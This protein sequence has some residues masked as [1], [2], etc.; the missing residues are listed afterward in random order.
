[1]YQR[2]DFF[3]ADRFGFGGLEC[4]R[5]SQQPV[6]CGIPIQ[7]ERK[8]IDEVLD[9]GK[10]L[11]RQP[12]QFCKQ[13]HLWRAHG[14][15]LHSRCCNH[16]VVRHGPANRAGVNAA[17][18]Y[19]SAGSNTTRYDGN[20]NLH[21]IT[22][23]FGGS[24]YRSF[25]T[26]QAGRILQKIQGGQNEY[27]F[28]ANDKPLGSTGSNG[29]A[30][31]DFNYTPVSDRYPATTPGSYVVAQGDTLRS[32]AAAMFGDAGLWYLVADANG[33]SSDSQLVI[34]RSLTIPNR[35]S[36]LHNNYQTF[37][38]Y[39]P[40]EII[41][42]TTPTLP[43]PPPPPPASG[44]G[45]C[46]GIGAVLSVIVTVVVAIYAPY[47]LQL[48]GLQ[49]AVVG[50][51]AGNIAGQVV[52][53]I[54]GVQDGF[55]FK[56]LATSVISAGITHG[57]TNGIG[58]LKDAAAGF[59]WATAAKAAITSV[60]HQGIN[61]VTGQQQKF[62]WKGVA[63]AAIAAPV[64][65]GISNV[66]SGTAEFDGQR[67]AGVNYADPQA[68]SFGQ[69]LSSGLAAGV[70]ATA[71]RQAVYGGGRMNF[72]QV[73]ADAFG[74]ALGQALM[75]SAG[76][77]A[78]PVSAREAFLE[79]SYA[80]NGVTGVVTDAPVVDAGPQLTDNGIRYS[81]YEVESGI[82]DGNPDHQLSHNGDGEEI[83]AEDLARDAF[84]R[85]QSDAVREK[86]VAEARA[87]AREQRLAREAQAVSAQNDRELNRTASL[88]EMNAKTGA[89]QFAISGNISLSPENMYTPARSLIG[90]AY[91]TAFR[92]V[93]NPSNTTLDRGAMGALAAATAVP[94][95]INDAA[96][97]VYNSFNNLYVGAQRMTIGV[98]TGDTRQFSDGLMQAS[99]GLLDAA[100]TGAVAK[101][102]VANEVAMA[103][104]QAAN[105]ESRETY[106]ARYTYDSSVS[107][108]R[109]VETGQFVAARDLP[110]PENAGFGSS[111]RITVQPGKL[112]DRF[113]D[114]SGRFLG[115]PGTT[116]SQRGMAPGADGM[117]Y[118]QY[119]VLKPID[120]RVGPA[121]SVPQFG[122][123]G[124][125]TQ[126]LPS[127]T[128][129]QLVKDKY[130]ERLK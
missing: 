85:K 64:A 62:D 7:F 37:K 101:T 1:M 110:W 123:V 36:N 29:V 102:V 44:G 120:M 84:F 53:N 119:R 68:L 77:G 31:F 10:C 98:S 71:V 92:E 22:D 17:V 127:R 82:D 78:Q 38:P 87:L 56:S 97:G 15:S 124:G 128:V 106:N 116:I 47:A 114:E 63:A 95:F 59:N 83:T 6:K 40:G 18:T 99:G 41:G 126:Y 79:N 58:V 34:G 46:G 65:A 75:P 91:R 109:N 24:N 43:D 4:R 9:F 66:V 5:N 8:K 11:R 122:A 20:G 108:Y 125:S 117:P 54:T 57:I 16:S 25:I 67:L 12:L 72:S 49:A 88:V 19:F 115:E 48:Q 107:R 35:I 51:A 76:T 27:Y 21:D 52:G 70:S 129:E 121:A 100:M 23:Q 105:L 26:D 2:G 81:A 32:I 111:T 86:D 103:R 69:R 104:A 28:Y 55:S 73:A 118:N 74:N 130:L 60:V 13:L 89:G 39:A 61:V 90:D 94:G 14:I 33:I 96:A 42:D 30:D 113:G 112:L 93:M 45:G 50:A 80:Q 3:V